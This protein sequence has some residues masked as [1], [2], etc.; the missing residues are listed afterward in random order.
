MVYIALF[1]AI[2]AVLGLLPKVQLISGVPVTAQSMGVM[3]AGG[4]LGAKRG[5][6]AL[7]LFVLLVLA[8]MPLLAG[9]RGGLGILASPSGG[10]LLGFPIATFAVGWLIEKN[11]LRLNLV[12]AVACCLIGG[13]LI[14]YLVGVPWMA[15]V[16]DFSPRQAFYLMLPY[17]PGDL[18]KAVLAAMLIMFVKRSYPIIRIQR[19]SA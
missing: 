18:V 16:G 7:S 3:L 6:L 12:L 4:V 1:A 9:G 14:L 19:I 17:L 13:I 11:W 2:V 10:F 8:G 15:T 5:A